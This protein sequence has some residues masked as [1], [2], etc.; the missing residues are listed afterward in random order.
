MFYFLKFHTELFSAF[1]PPGIKQRNRICPL[2]RHGKAPYTAYILRLPCR[3]WFRRFF[4]LHVPPLFQASEANFS[5]CSVKHSLCWF[6]FCLQCK[7]TSFVRSIRWKH[8]DRCV[9]PC[10]WN[11]VFASLGYFNKLQFKKLFFFS[12]PTWGKSHLN[13]IAR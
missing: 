9:L 7:C 10:F 8:R 13:S 12:A 3:N 2:W 1:F 5:G 11:S 4:R 6:C